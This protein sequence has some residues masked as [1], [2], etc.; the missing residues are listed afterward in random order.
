MMKSRRNKD[1][2]S[3]SM[4]LGFSD[5][6]SSKSHQLFYCARV[7]RWC[8]YLAPATLDWTGNAKI[9]QL[10]K[11]SSSSSPLSGSLSH[12]TL[13]F[14]ELSM[15]ALTGADVGVNSG[16]GAG[17]P[18]KDLVCDLEVRPTPTLWTKTRLPHQFLNESTADDEIQIFWLGS[19][20][21]SWFRLCLLALIQ[22]QL[23]F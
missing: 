11:P 3:E 9:N 17:W 13:S 21:P 8:K 4:F 19:S 16:A 7:I 20:S 1:Q 10:Q 5:P 14:S 23:H 12:P 2:P 22:L 15:A 6:A 18:E